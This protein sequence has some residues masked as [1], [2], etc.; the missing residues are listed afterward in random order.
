MLSWLNWLE[1]QSQIR[2]LYL[3][4]LCSKLQHIRLAKYL[5]IKAN[6]LIVPDANTVNIPF[7][8]N[9]HEFKSL[10]INISWTQMRMLY[11]YTIGHKQMH[12]TL[13]AILWL[14][15]S[16]AVYIN[17]WWKV[18]CTTLCFEVL[19]IYCFKEHSLLLTE[20]ELLFMQSRSVDFI[21]PLK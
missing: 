16:R 15:D 10:M 1:K 9:Q 4:S 6:M 11:I 8:N 20:M 19:N 7:Y 13:C 12:Y 2:L 14:F 21:L 18:I 3:S 5:T 17:L